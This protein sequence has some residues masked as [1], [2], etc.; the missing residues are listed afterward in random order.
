MFGHSTA[1][2]LD[3]VLVR[4][5]SRLAALG[6]SAHAASLLAKKPDA[7]RNLQ[8]A[9]RSGD[10]R[11]ITTETLSALAPRSGDDGGV[12]ARRCRRRASEQPRAGRRPDRSRCRNPAGVRAGSPRGPSMKS[13]CPFPMPEESIAFEVEGDSMWP[14]YDPGDVIICWRQGTD[15]DEVVG[16]EAAVRTAD[17]KRYLKRIRRGRGQRDIRSRE[18]QRRADPQCP[19]RMGGR[20]PGGGA[21]RTMDPAG[22]RSGGGRRSVD[23][24]W[25]ARIR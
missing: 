19:D 20:D 8:R 13:R 6:L 25:A 11:G 5:E 23:L 18:P 3:D 1:M 15:A 14:R 24:P 10:R 7:I 16:W 17:G 12:A 2:D 21:G 4:I 9:V 22:K